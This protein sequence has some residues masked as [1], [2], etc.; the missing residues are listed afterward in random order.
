LVSW[1]FLSASCMFWLTVSSIIS[2]K[3]SV[4]LAGF[5]LWGCSSGYPLVPSYH[6]SLFCWKLELGICFLHTPLN[7]V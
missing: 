4:F 2:I 7:P 6:L 3:F 5:L 1:K